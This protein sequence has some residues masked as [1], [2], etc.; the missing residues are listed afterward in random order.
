MNGFVCTLL[1]GCYKTKAGNLIIRLPAIAII[2]NA[3]NQSLFDFV[4]IR[5]HKIGTFK[6]ISEQISVAP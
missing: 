1:K 5:K 3:I 2:V 4:P 6:H